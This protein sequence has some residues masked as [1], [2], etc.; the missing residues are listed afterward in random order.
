[1]LP[2][3][4]LTLLF[5]VLLMLRP[6][7][8]LTADSPERPLFVVLLPG[9]QLEDLSRYEHMRALSEKG[10]LGLMNA[11]GGRN[12]AAAYL[13][14]A[15][16]ARL[17]CSEREGSLLFQ[18]D[19]TYNG[20]DVTSL[21]RRYLD[22][23]PQD[24]AVL[25]P[26]LMSLLNSAGNPEITFLADV[27][28][29]K[30]SPFL[31]IGSQDLPGVISR[32]G[33]L[34]ALNSAGT[35]QSGVVDH[36]TYLESA[37]SPTLYVT[38]YDFYYEEAAGF[39]SAQPGLVFLDLGDLARLEARSSYLSAEVY[40]KWRHTLL[41]EADRFLGRLL[42][43]AGGSA[44]LLLLAPYPAP[45]AQQSGDTLVPVLHLSPASSPGLLCSASTKRPGIITNLDIAPTILELRG[46]SKPAAY[47]GSPV[48]TVPGTDAF[49][50][51]SSSH[52]QMLTN[53]QQ[54]PVI[55]K[56]Y[57]FMLIAVLLSIA[58]FVLW[59]RAWFQKSGPFLLFILVAPL[60]FLLLPLLPLQGLVSRIVFLACAGI[61]LVFLLEKTLPPI[62]RLALL[63]LAT[64]AFITADLLL[65]APLMQQS[66]LGYDAISGARYYGIGNEYM[67][68][69]LGSGF[70][71]F[72]LLLEALSSRFPHRRAYLVTLVCL[73]G[74][75]LLV[76]VAAPQ[77]G[78]NVGGAISFTGSLV[79]LCFLLANRKISLKSLGILGLACAGVTALLFFID[80]Q[81][82]LEV[83]SHI[84]L[85][86]RMIHEEGL[87]YLLT[88]IFR[89][90]STNLRLLQYSLWGRAFI[91]SMGATALVFYRPSGSLHKLFQAHPFL[92]S[93]FTAAFSGSL[94][95]LVVNDSGIVAAATASIFIVPTLLYLISKEEAGR[96]AGG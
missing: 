37:A 43:Y 78:T 49:T 15:A 10:A 59:N 27:L 17:S 85:T 16:G 77:W 7:S 24:A 18:S 54:R 69:L 58:A 73:A 4:F 11:G 22:K 25:M 93:G 66:L 63:Y 79:L 36:R 60:L 67:G 26:S 34:I 28:T 30:G 48:Y 52:E 2:R 33:A 45:A 35:V 38:D 19:E 6:V 90:I 96:E 31:F 51:L 55:L 13:S 44:E 92:R 68:V 62:P 80:L 46:L 88:V 56:G 89:K 20:Q 3:F 12:A 40:G 14:L 64:A 75:G 65:G 76:L 82:P 32:P 9:L 91:I 23:P 87:P 47:I 5:F 74:A 83:Q 1:M 21:Y 95:A 41:Q 39:I 57:V 72:T 42:G 71:G 53:Y 50:F 61:F 8:S 29:K 84:G 86:A 81:R 94:I 70:I